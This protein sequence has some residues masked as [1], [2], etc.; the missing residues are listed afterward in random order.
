MRPAAFPWG[1]YTAPPEIA[2]LGA[3]GARRQPRHSVPVMLAPAFPWG[4]Y[5]VPSARRGGPR[6]LMAGGGRR[7]RY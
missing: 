4:S 3:L 2:T 7:F 1:R 5:T 6:R